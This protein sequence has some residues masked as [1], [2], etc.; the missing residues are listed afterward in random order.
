MSLEIQQLR[1]FLAVAEDLSF[2]SAARRLHISPSPLSQQIR[3]LET[4]VGQRLFER[5]SR[6]VR[7]T[8]A[9]EFLLPAARRIVDDADALVA[10]LRN[11]GALAA[12]PLHL[13]YSGNLGGRVYSRLLRRLLDQY[14]MIQPSIRELTGVGDQF[15]ALSRGEVDIALT[16]HPAGVELADDLDRLVL[17]TASILAVVREDSE[18]AAAGSLALAELAGTPLVTTDVAPTHPFVRYMNS[19]IEATGA[20]LVPTRSAGGYGGLMD[21]ILAGLGTGFS[22]SGDDRL[23]R[24]GI[25]TVPIVDPVPRLEI[26][27]AWRRTEQRAA[28]LV[29]KATIE[30]L[31]AEHAFAGLGDQD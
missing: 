1:S 24:K 21:M 25:R 5:N 7:L 17:G 30:E 16:H 18:F 15:R 22:V 13:G 29:A 8:E 6:S 14:P 19:L 2:A 26:L 23:L 10:E 3:A 9:G 27:A 11:F 12:G 20:K 28:V 31:H 4:R